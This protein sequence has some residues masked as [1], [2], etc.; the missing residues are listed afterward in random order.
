MT[1]ENW[2]ELMF[3][4]VVLFGVVF[5]VGRELNDDLK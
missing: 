3:W 5:I 1:I 4:T 2:V